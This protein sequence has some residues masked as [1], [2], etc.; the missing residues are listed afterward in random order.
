MAIFENLPGIREDIDLWR[1]PFDPMKEKPDDVIYQKRIDAID[2][3]ADEFEQVV[4]PLANAMYDVEGELHETDDNGNVYM[5]DGRLLPNI[6]YTLNG[7]T[8]TTD[9]Y[10]RIIKCEGAPKLNPENTR[11]TEAQGQVGG[12]DRRPNDQGGH[13]IS[14]D[15]DG[16]GGLG[17]LIP[18]DAR[19]NQ[20]DYKKMESDIKKALQEGKEVTTETEIAYDGDSERPSTIT[21][22]VTI[23]GEK[24]VY[25]F[26]NNLDGSLNNKVPEVAKDLVQMTLDE[27]G[28]VVSSTEEKY[29]EKGNL[30]EMT[31][32]ITYTD[33][34]GKN[35]RTKVVVENTQGG[36]MG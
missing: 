36:T 1:K 18:M 29:D 14:R 6:T 21:T 25:R 8:Y 15:M 9:E 20:S 7:Y 12:A 33:D 31:I 32:T 10:G 30:K 34:N 2:V 17:N 24:T 23:D 4:N 19:I 11:N 28:G 16:D 26:D 22:T 35:H 5:I 3:S 13:V 27:T